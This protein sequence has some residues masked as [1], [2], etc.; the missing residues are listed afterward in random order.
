MRGSSMARSSLASP[1]SGVWGAVY[2]RLQER[3]SF[4]TPGDLARYLNAR[5]I[6]TPALELIDEKLVHLVRSHV[7]LSRHER[8][9]SWPLTD[10][11]R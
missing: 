3:R 7:G 10:S 9:A 8:L 6:D 11:D 1:P 2:D 4:A 5:I